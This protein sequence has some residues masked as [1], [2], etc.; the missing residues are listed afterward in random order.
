MK[1]RKPETHALKCSVG[2]FF[3]T[4]FSLNDHTDRNV[5]TKQKLHWFIHFSLS[6]LFKIQDLRGVLCH[7]SHIHSLLCDPLKNDGQYNINDYVNLTKLKQEYYNFNQSGLL[8][9]HH[10]LFKLQVSSVF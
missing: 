10:L 7:S 2:R 4:K 6:S 9:V 8:F 1:I 5:L 3:Q